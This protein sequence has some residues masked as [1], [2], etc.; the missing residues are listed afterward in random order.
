MLL[1]ICE[2]CSIEK[3]GFIGKLK[4]HSAICSAMGKE[5]LFICIYAFCLWGGIG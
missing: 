5:I 1:V 2:S 4:H 3:K